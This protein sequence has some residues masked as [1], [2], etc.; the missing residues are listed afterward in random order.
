MQ[1]LEEPNW[2][3]IAFFHS[4]VMFTLLSTALVTRQLVWKL[5][6]I[7]KDEYLLANNYNYVSM[8]MHVIQYYRLQ[9][10]NYTVL[11]CNTLIISH[12]KWNDCTDLVALLIYYSSTKSCIIKNVAMS[13][14]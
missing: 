2:Q 7:L 11:L 6:V 9:Y 13:K 10:D 3:E 4:V 14:H 1:E 12:R 5:P 8:N